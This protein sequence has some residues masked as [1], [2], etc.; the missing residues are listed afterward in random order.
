MLSARNLAPR[1][2]AERAF[3]DALA[4]AR[5]PSI[6]PTAFRIRSHR[7]IRNEYLQAEARC[8]LDTHG[9]ATVHAD[10]SPLVH[11]RQHTCWRGAW[12]S[13]V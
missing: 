5:V 10:R 6:W 4:A 8:Q 1:F 12:T 13:R 9:A 3:L 2:A 7:T 11:L